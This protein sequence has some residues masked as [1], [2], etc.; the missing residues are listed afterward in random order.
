MLIL[1][2]IKNWFELFQ[3]TNL[4]ARGMQF[5]NTPDTYYKNLKER[6]KSAPI[7]V[8]E[9]IDVVSTFRPVF[10]ITPTRMRDDRQALAMDSFTVQPFILIVDC[11]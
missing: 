1:K 7:T 10:C 4:R 9:D 3:I 6:L 8:T 11:L 5:L 2:I